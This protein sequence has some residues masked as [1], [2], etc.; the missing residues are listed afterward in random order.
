MDVPRVPRK[1]RADLPTVWIDPLDKWLDLQTVSCETLRLAADSLDREYRDC[2]NQL[3][4]AVDTAIGG[5][6]KLDKK[7]MRLGLAERYLASL[8]PLRKL[9]W[10]IVQFDQAEPAKVA[11]RLR[12]AADLL[13]AVDDP[14]ILAHSTIHSV[15]SLRS[16]AEGGVGAALAYRQLRDELLQL[17][18]QP[19]LTLSE[20]G[21]VTRI[22]EQAILLQRN[23]W[24]GFSGPDWELYSK[25]KNM[26][27]RVI[28]NGEA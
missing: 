20:L 11:Q 25:R 21:Y 15:D 18:G 5:V 16:A 1:R 26:D 14:R 24:W 22:R 4:E 12:E 17:A 7:R 27:W 3:T 6:E 28:Q 2:L 13:L 23:R 10:Q 9:R 19:Q 8:G